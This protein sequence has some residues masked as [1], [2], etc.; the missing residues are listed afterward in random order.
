MTARGVL[1]VAGMAVAVVGSAVVYSLIPASV[2]AVDFTDALTGPDSPQFDIPFDKYTLTPEGLL[3]AHSA[4]GRGNGTDRPVIRTRS[5][6]YLSRDF[7]FEVDIT[8][9]ADVQDIAFI[10]FGSGAPTPPFNEPSGVFGLRIHYLPGNRQVRFAAI[11]IAGSPAKAAY[12][13]EETIGAF[14][15]EGPLTVRLERSGDHIT[16]SL[17]GQEGSERTL[18][19]SAYP[20]V[21]T[22][23][24]FLYLSNTA[25]GT[26]FSNVKVRP[27]L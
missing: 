11:S 24:G 26:T 9:P 4:S 19:I 3:R 14:P 25:E 5:D 13:F 18:R 20:T 15:T 10:G 7:I 17:P 16:A 1:I 22:G 6:Q 21:L 12:L 8:I 27:R 2:P 23:R